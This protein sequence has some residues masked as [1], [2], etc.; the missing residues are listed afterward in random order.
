MIHQ[1]AIISD[2][3]NIGDNVSIGPFCIVGDNVTLGNNVKLHS[4]VVVE[5]N[6]KIGDNCEIF[7]FVSIGH[8]PQDLKFKGEA[9]KITIGKNCQI[10]EHVTINPGTEGGNMHTQVGDS[11]LLMVGSHVAHDCVVGNNVI[12]ANNATLAGHVTVGDNVIIGGLSAVRQWVRIGK[13][14]IIGGMSGIENDVIPYG[15]AHGE[16]ATLAGLNLVGLKR[17]QFSKDDINALRK[18]FKNIF[19]KQGK[20]A[21]N[22][23]STK[24]DFTNS[25]PV[26]DIIEFLQG[27]AANSFCKPK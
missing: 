2:K 11:C 24:N 12:L 9:S 15:M 16:R 27:D 14:A 1:T 8:K 4:H 25:T 13:N 21:D 20:F 5:G 7:P 19:G 18:A 23:A 26:Q 6:T 22:V 17:A 10:R 3:A